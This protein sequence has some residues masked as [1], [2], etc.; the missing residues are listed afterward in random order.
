MND[1]WAHQQFGFRKNS[2]TTIA[3]VELMNFIYESLDNKNSN[4]CTG[5]F[6]DLRKAFDTVNHE[7]LLKKLFCA[8]VRGVAN[9]LLKSYLVNRKQYVHLR[10]TDSCMMNVDIGVPQGSVLGPT[11]YLIFTNDLSKV[12]LNGKLFLY[13]DD[14]ALFYANQTDS[15][16]C[17]ML[18]A[19]LNILGQYFAKNL[20]TMNISKTKFMHIC[21]YN[22]L[23][24]EDVIVRIGDQ[25]I[26][27][28]RQYTYL[29][30][31]LDERLSW[32]A[33]CQMVTK[34][35]T[36]A[37]GALFKYRSFLNIYDMYFVFIHSHLFYMVIIWGNASN[38]YLRQVQVMQ[39]RALK[40]VFGLH[41]LSSTID[42]FSEYA[43][44]VLSVKGLHE[45][46]ILK[47]VR[48]SLN[49]EILHTFSFQQLTDS[50]H[51][52]YDLRDRH[53]RLARPMVRT[54]FGVRMM[55]YAGP[56]LFNKLSNEVRANT[57]TRSFAL[58][59][60]KHLSTRETLARLLNK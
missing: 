29:G 34:R 28:V 7:L 13:A 37:V 39:N 35:V 33:Q 48:Q 22:K 54:L 12:E 60:K 14:A 57:S 2:N 16:N 49:D 51:M 1:F 4:V 30:L 55:T 21:S 47:Y 41:R 58:T 10:D 40:F 53:F 45:F 36:S 26:E 25:V 24:N 27:R 6:V 23:L 15:H 8:G 20:L 50:R 52:N 31:I 18:N 17:V 11:L 59:I 46:C 43:K 9:E 32:S 42:V 44:N 56:T 3:V 38:V 5:L 19:D